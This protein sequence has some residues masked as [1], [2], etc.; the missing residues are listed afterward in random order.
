MEY[1]IRRL[2]W[3]GVTF[4]QR[5]KILF[6]TPKEIRC[7]N[8]KDRLKKAI[9]KDP[10]VYSCLLL[11]IHLARIYIYEE[12]YS[13]AEQAMCHAIRGINAIK[14]SGR[15]ELAADLYRRSAEVVMQFPATGLH[16]AQKLYGLANKL[17]AKGAQ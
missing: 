14:E 8:L 12:N 1:A 4:W 15:R 6:F 13:D 9:E 16:Y 7:A 2:V 11:Y 17:E 5:V 10:G 3:D